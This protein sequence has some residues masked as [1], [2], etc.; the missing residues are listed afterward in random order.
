MH[1][2]W[3]ALVMGTKLLN[4]FVF[5][6]FVQSYIWLNAAIM[7]RFIRKEFVFQGKWLISE[8]IKRSVLKSSFSTDQNNSNY[9]SLMPVY[10]C[11]PSKSSTFLCWKQLQVKL[12]SSGVVNAYDFCTALQLT[13]FSF[14]MLF[15]GR[16]VWIKSMTLFLT[17][18]SFSSKLSIFF[19][20]FSF[21]IPLFFL[22]SLSSPSQLFFITIRTPWTLVVCFLSIADISFR[23]ISGLAGGFFHN[24]QVYFIYLFFAVNN[25]PSPLN[26]SDL[27]SM[28]GRAV[29]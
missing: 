23:F 18:F 29:D 10:P 24:S 2:S 15:V 9:F 11:Y 14:I 27:Q 1:K 28:R 19:Q 26:L 7:Q 12:S 17:Y 16:R 4:L 6:C 3:Y 5:N 13:S 20:P 21:S 22:L 25:S 8:W